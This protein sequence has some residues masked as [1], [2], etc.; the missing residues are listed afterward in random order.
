MSFFKNIN[1]P[2]NYANSPAIMSNIKSIEST[3][4]S[5]ITDWIKSYTKLP[6]A[7]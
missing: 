3:K 6:Q 1:N 5:P 2:K 4:V 7:E